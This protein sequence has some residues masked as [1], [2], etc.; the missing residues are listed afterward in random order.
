MTDA[1]GFEEAYRLEAEA[2]VL[3]DRQPDSND[4]LGQPRTCT[5]CQHTSVPRPWTPG[6][7]PD[8]ERGWIC[9]DCSRK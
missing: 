5:A 1:G 7:T 4:Q 6:W 3:A 8:R 9:P 2:R